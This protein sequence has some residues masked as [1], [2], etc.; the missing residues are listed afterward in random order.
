[1]ECD[2]IVRTKGD[3]TQ[4][5]VKI[6]R[7]RPDVA[8]KRA[9]RA[10]TVETVVKACLLKHLRGADRDKIRKA[11]ALRTA[12]FSRRMHAASLGLLH[13]V[14]ARFEGVSNDQL[15]QVD[16]PPVD[17]QTFIRQLMLGVAGAD[18]P[19]PVV[20][21]LHQANPEYLVSA[22]RYLGDRNIYSEG[23]K[24]YI[25]NLTNHL[26]THTLDYLKRA[27]YA[28]PDR[29]QQEGVAMW[30]MVAGM[31]PHCAGSY[32]L[33]Q[34]DTLFVQTCRAILGL[35]APD[36]RINNE[37]LADSSNL[38][39][40]LRLFVYLNRHI[41]TANQGRL[42]S[43]VPV[44]K[45]RA[46]FVHVDTSVLNGLLRE[47]GLVGK[48]SSLDKFS[49]V[50]DAQWRS[51]FAIDRLQGRNNQ[52]TGTIQTDGVSI[53]VHFKRPKNDID[54]RNT[55]LGASSSSPAPA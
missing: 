46:H 20:A 2:G 35:A 25:T 55:K 39:K 7:T 6:K 49:A 10:G 23:A 38:P 9:S 44:C 21:A 14:Q 37:W 11:L 30:T 17:D 27:A 32:P 54:I 5:D 34:A 4:Q 48:A 53:C 41:A 3:D 36:S 52:F 15:G 24:Q 43:L 40:V 26:R 42:F 13:I 22:P 18:L 16:V 8:E 12:A 47:V 45:V 29:T 28:Q 51:V 50:A 19:N 33:R 1:M 31:T